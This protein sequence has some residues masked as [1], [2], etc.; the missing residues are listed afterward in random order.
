MSHYNEVQLYTNFGSIYSYLQLGF[1][2]LAAS[3]VIVVDELG[4]TV[5]DST[6]NTVVLDES[7][8]A[9]FSPFTVLQSSQY[10]FRA[11]V[12]LASG[13]GRFIQIAL[14][15]NTP[16]EV[17]ILNSITYIFRDTTST[18]IKAHS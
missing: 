17:F 2:S 1:N 11:L 13:R 15:H 4:N 10:V 6:D 12:P 8:D 5:T 18:K 3:N 9:L 14:K 7:L 16:N